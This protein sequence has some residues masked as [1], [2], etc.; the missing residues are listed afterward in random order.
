MVSGCD[1]PSVIEPAEHARSEVAA[2]VGPAFYWTDGISGGLARND[3]HDVILDEPSP[4]LNGIVDFVRIQALCRSLGFQKRKSQKDV[5]DVAGVSVRATS[6]PPASARQWIFVV[7]LLRRR[8]TAWLNSP[9]PIR[10]ETESLHRI[11]VETKLVQNGACRC[12]PGEST[13]TDVTPSLS[14]VAVVDRL[15]GPLLGRHISPATARL[16]N[17]QDVRNHP[18]VIVR[19]LAELVL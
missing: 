2:A 5:G 3:W 12:D 16:L 10:S 6:R 18:P 11:A 4:Q 17:M 9:F 15:G 7:R 14:G 8:Q 13:L 1:A 19:L